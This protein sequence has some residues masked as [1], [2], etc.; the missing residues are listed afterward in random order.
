MRGRGH[1]SVSAAGLEAPAR[2]SC[3][4][5]GPPLICLTRVNHDPVL[6]VRLRLLSS[7]LQEL[8]F[9]TRC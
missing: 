3:S 7:C 9:E 6:A 8:P 5:C 2:V 4:L 1:L